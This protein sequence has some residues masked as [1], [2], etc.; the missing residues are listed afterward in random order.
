MSG[1][2]LFLD[3]ATRTGWCEGVP[4]ETPTSGTLRLAPAGSSPAAVYGGLVAFLGTRL[5]ALRY[6]AVAYEA[7]MDPRHMK[8]NINTARVLLGM[9]AI[10]EGLAY[11]TGHH[12]LF[13]ANVHD[14]RKHLLGYRPQAGEAKRVV[15]GALRQL[16]FDPRDDN[17]GDAIAGWLYACAVLSPGTAAAS[18]PLIGRRT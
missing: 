8:T 13:E 6:R 9:P 11:Q 1:S 2:V 14:V 12:R 7:P 16:G 15:M 17:E 4:G 5:T 18:T 3:L 10:V